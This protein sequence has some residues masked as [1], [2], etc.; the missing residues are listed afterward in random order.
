MASLEALDNVYKI[1]MM[2]DIHHSFYKLFKNIKRHIPKSCI[3]LEPFRKRISIVS[4]NGERII[5]GK[6]SGDYIEI[7]IKKDDRLLDLV[8]RSIISQDK[9]T[10]NYRLFP[11]RCYYAF[12]ISRSLM[13]MDEK[14][15]VKALKKTFGGGIDVDLGSGDVYVIKYGAIVTYIKPSSNEDEYYMFT[16]SEVY[17]KEFIQKLERIKARQEK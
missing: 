6:A 7:S 4:E 2:S 15:L 17:G 9:Y 13:P 5:E 16:D 3:T 8:K 1:K 14:D 11:I 10:R 12:R